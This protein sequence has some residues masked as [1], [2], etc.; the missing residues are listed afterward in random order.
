[1]DKTAELSGC[2][3][4]CLKEWGA[5]KTDITGVGKDPAHLGRRSAVIGTVAFI[6]QDENVRVG[7][8]QAVLAPNRIKFINDGGNDAGLTFGNEPHKMLTGVGLFRRLA[9]GLETSARSDR[10]DRHDR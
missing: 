5:G 6:H 9:A 8:L 2:A 1:M 4:F 10:P 3:F 7:V